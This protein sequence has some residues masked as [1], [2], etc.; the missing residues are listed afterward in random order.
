MISMRVSQIRVEKAA[1]MR[2]VK[3]S[4]KSPLTKCALLVENEAKRSMKKG[5]RPAKARGP[6]GGRARGTPSAPG[7]P[8]H[9]QTGN[10]RASITHAMV[11]PTLAIVGPTREAWYGKVHEFGGRYHP[12]RPF[13]RPA[14]NRE[15]SKF[16]RQFGGCVK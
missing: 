16:A 5:G 13:M 2:R 15:K 7:T 9:V 3:S 11:S 4:V 8:P 6:R 1:V 10:L 12:K 14:L